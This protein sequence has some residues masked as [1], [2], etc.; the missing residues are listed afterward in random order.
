MTAAPALYLHLVRL[1][2]SENRTD[3]IRAIVLWG[4]AHRTLV[5]LLGNSVLA[6]RSWSA[7][8]VIMN[9]TRN[10]WN[11]IDLDKLMF[12]HIH[13]G[14]STLNRPKEIFWKN[15]KDYI[16]EEYLCEMEDILLQKE[17]LLYTDESA[18]SSSSKQPASQGTI[19]DAATRVLHSINR[20]QHWEF[21]MGSGRSLLVSIYKRFAWDSCNRWRWI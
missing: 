2:G 20:L 7:M 3:Q 11:F 16:D 10:S 14:F 18:S 17:T 13:E 6:E 15:D 1:I 5:M 9:K 19:G 4:L 8:N 21:Q 12:I